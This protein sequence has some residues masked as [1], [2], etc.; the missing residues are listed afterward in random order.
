M[1]TI[2]LVTKNS[3]T[4]GKLKNSD[5][6]FN[7]LLAAC[8]GSLVRSGRQRSV[9]PS[10]VLKVRQAAPGRQAGGQAGS[11]SNL[12]VRISILSAAATAAAAR[13]RDAVVLVG[14][15]I[16]R[17]PTGHVLRFASQPAACS[18]REY[19]CFVVIVLVTA[20]AGRQAGRQPPCTA[21]WRS[22]S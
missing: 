19:L 1:F 15:L 11:S 18:P 13:A 4:S 22:V 8:L 14:L 12:T 9:R 16:P 10:A 21:R 5:K 3:V 17:V 20:S 6:I 2:F 7:I